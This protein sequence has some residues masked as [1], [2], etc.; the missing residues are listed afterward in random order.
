MVNGNSLLG[1]S[2]FIIAYITGVFHTHIKV[3]HHMKNTFLFLVMV[4]PEIFPSPLTFISLLI[5]PMYL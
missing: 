5:C 4:I 1:I 3:R 2:M